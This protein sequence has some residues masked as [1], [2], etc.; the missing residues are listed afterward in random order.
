MRY[1]LLAIGFISMVM[2]SSFVIGSALMDEE[3]N[4]QIEK[5]IFKK[6]RQNN[7]V[8]SKLT[9]EEKEWIYET[10]LL[11][12]LRDNEDSEFNNSADISR[13]L[14]QLA[15]F[16]DYKG[17]ANLAYQRYVQQAERDLKDALSGAEEVIGLFNNLIKRGLLN[18]SFF[19]Q[20]ISKYSEDPDN[21][22]NGKH[23][24]LIGENGFKD[25]V[26]SLAEAYKHL[27]KKTL[28]KRKE[29]NVLPIPLYDKV[30]K[31]ILAERINQSQT[32]Q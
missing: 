16:Y 23:K 21:F 8:P 9:Q 32:N 5:R 3:Q 29:S 7:F 19:K 4:A 2:S 24:G 17:R 13:I 28:E 6:A 1:S 12:T 25:H 11:G 14:G 30:L 15:D 18:D 22:A 27:S 10:D 20:I 26:A 31:L